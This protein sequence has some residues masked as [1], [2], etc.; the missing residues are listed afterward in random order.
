MQHIHKF[1]HVYCIMQYTSHISEG[2]WCVATCNLER[3]K[4]PTVGNSIPGKKRQ[5]VGNFNT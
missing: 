3:N 4:Q 1:S 5:N 2:T